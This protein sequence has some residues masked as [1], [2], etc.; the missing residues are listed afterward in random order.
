VLGYYLLTPPIPWT[1]ETG[2]TKVYFFH[3]LTCPHCVRE[4]QFLENLQEKYPG[5]EIEYLEAGENTELFKEMCNRYN[6]VHGPVPA[7]FTCDKAFI[8]YSPEDGDSQ[9]MENYRAYTG[10][11]NQLEKAIVDCMKT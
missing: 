10:Y 5:L 1:D 3:S 4:K 2:N 11:T 6:C 9:Y 7:T 8:G